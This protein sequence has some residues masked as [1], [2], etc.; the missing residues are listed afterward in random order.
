[1]FHRQPSF[2]LALLLLAFSGLRLAAA[3][4]APNG[5]RLT[6]LDSNDPFY[7]HRDFPKL[8]TP[9]WVGEPGVEAVVV[10]AIDDMRETSK[11]ETFLRPVLERLKK[12]D[13]RAPVSIMT[14]TN[15]VQ[16]PRLQSWLKEGLSIEVH[17]MTHP[18]P[19]L[20]NGNFNAAAANYNQCI[21]LLSKIPGNKPVAFRM[22]CCDSMNSPSPRF[23]SE[24]FPQ[25]TPNGNFLGIDSSVMVLLTTNDPA[26]PRELVRDADGRSKFRKYFPAQTNKITRLSLGSFATYIEDYP[27]PYV[28]DRVCWEFPCIVPSDWEAQNVHGP[29]SAALLADWKAGL[30]AVVLKQGVF[31]MIFHPHGWSKPE[32]LAELVDYADKKYGSKVKF[33]NFREAYDRLNKH[34]L[35]GNP[36]RNSAGL[37]NGVR[38]LDIDNDG[39]MDVL[40]GPTAHIWRPKTG[41]WDKFPGVGPKPVEI[42]QGREAKTGFAFGV[43]DKKGDAA[44]IQARGLTPMKHILPRTPGNLLDMPL[45][46]LE[47]DGSP[48]VASINGVD[49]GVRL[50]DIDHDGISELIVSNPKQNAIFQWNAS[51]HTWKR[52]PYALPVG[53]MIVDAEGRDAGLRF[54]DVNGDGFDDVIFS[55]PERYSLHLFIPKPN[56]LGWK[57]GW[58]DEIVSAPRKG[59]DGIPM[60]VR[61]GSHP[62]NGVWFKDGT[63]WIQNEDTA[64]LPAQVDRRTFKQLLE[65]G[66][67]KPLSPQE[68]LKAIRARPGFTVELVASE[69]L[70]QDPIAFEWGADGK[71]WV[72]EMGDYPRGVD[73]HGKAGGHIKFLEDTDGDGRYDK[74]TTF[75]DNVP[76]PTGV[77]PWGRG[78]IISAAPN[79]FYAEDTDGDGKADQQRILF[80]G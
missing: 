1:M 61:G 40:I 26:L 79:I 39:Y 32:Q 4:P 50:R 21:D 55:N 49:Q 59:K 33:L 78:V 73:E 27:Y 15:D 2:I 38:L 68:S 62:D 12:I 29:N 44:F 69:P 31:T 28:I 66:Q 3:G 64:N 36:L 14:N 13:G 72:V 5:N 75:L 10:L 48:V 6:Y 45:T 7:V 76:F 17:T 8:T 20:A 67:P 19:C 37:D 74:A 71:L 53:T 47:L 16:N 30:D 34:L 25:I 60:I 70:V 9:Q 54:V 35:A 58:N 80:T 43:T 22:P 77:F 41:Q 24:I 42:V 18:C 57:I 51:D 63:M 52:L 23:Y 11:Y 56:Q 65:L 46:G